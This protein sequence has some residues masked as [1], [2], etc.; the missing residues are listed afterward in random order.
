MRNSNWGRDCSYFGSDRAET[1]D[2]EDVSLPTSLRGGSSGV[3]SSI[4]SPWPPV[5]VREPAGCNIAGV[6]LSFKGGSYRVFASYIDH[7]WLVDVEHGRAYDVPVV[8]GCEY[9]KLVK[10]GTQPNFVGFG[11]NERSGH[12]NP[13]R[14][15]R[16]RT[17]LRGK[18]N[19]PKSA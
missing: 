10:F 17:R 1:T 7:Q 18:S 9:E 6:A 16:Y 11:P 12:V 14:S 13:E 15:L 3:L 5:V 4:L 8:Y 2:P 19:T